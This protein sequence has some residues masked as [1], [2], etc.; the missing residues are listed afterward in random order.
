MK[1]VLLITS[2]CLS[3]AAC[4]TMGPQYSQKSIP[5]VKNSAAQLVVFRPSAFTG[6]GGP[7]FYVNDEKKCQVGGNG[8]FAVD[9]AAGTNTLVTDATLGTPSRMELDAKAGRRYYIKIE[10]NHAKS[11]AAGAFGL[12]G[13]ATYNAAAS[14]NADYKMEVLDADYAQSALKSMQMINCR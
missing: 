5:P 8:V 14:D 7:Y 6:P 3:L 13:V 12:I 11:T 2:L 9:I 1:N 10:E 4:A